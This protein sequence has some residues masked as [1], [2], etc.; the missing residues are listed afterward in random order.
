MGCC[1][2]VGQSNIG[3]IQRCGK[4][5][6]VAP[7]GLNIL[8]P[9]LCE[10]MAGRVSLR[11]QQLDVLCETKTKDN[12]FVEINVS[13]QYQ[14]V[15][16]NIYDAYYR[17]EDPTQQIQAYVYDV[18]RASV[19]Q[20]DLDDVFETKD[21]IAFTLKTE[22]GN[23]M[24]DYGFQILQALITE[25]EPNSKVKQAMND[26]NAAER[27]KHAAADTAE[28]KKILVVKAAEADSESK[29]LSGVG[30]ARQRLAIVEGLRDSV[31][32]FSENVEGASP[33]D[34]MDLVLVTQYFDTL[35]ELGSA[36][37]ARTI[38]IPHNGGGDSLEANL[39]DSIMQG[40]MIKQNHRTTQ[41]AHKRSHKK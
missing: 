15:Y 28:A 34:V 9:C 37:R 23:V 14:V 12:V 2:S 1:V 5:N 26:I 31:V 27:N 6:R 3:I 40:S 29:Y 18:V 41:G 39:R 36:S 16:D 25:I 19:P 7:A 17:L 13:V 38:F 22:L 32:S 4:F 33:K 10:S 21:E 24:E 35:K 20:I 8:N 11:I 30:I